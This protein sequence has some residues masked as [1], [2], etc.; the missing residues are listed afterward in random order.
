MFDVAAG[1]W[2]WTRTHPEWQ[3]GF[4]WEPAVSSFCVT[5]GGV[6]LVLDGLA[7]ADE[8]VLGAPGRPASERRGVP[9]A[10]PHP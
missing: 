3:L 5:S 1:L 4:D 9:Q 8:R 2:G 6:T 7:P 10:R